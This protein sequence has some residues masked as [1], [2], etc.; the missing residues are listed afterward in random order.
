[1]NRRMLL[2]TLSAVL[3]SCGLI[4]P[5][6]DQ[7]DAAHDAPP[8]FLGDFYC[9]GHEA[10]MLA[11]AGMLTIHAGGSATLEWMYSADPIAGTWL[12]EPE[13]DE[14]VFSVE[15]EISHALYNEA[16]DQLEVHL[17]EG[18]ERAHVET[19]VMYCQKQ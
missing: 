14:V 1:M 8:E 3:I 10:G 5:T 19:G 2:L 6:S 16:V 18:V 17:R 4:T 13:R 11:F 15:L 7:Q 12:Y 9:S